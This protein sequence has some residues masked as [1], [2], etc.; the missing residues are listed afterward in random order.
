M[1]GGQGRVPM[2]MRMPI[3]I[4]SS[5]AA[6]HSQSLEAWFAHIPGLV[7]VTPSTPADNH[8]LLLAALGKLSDGLM[9]RWERRTLAWRDSVGAAA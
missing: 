8:G 7:V 6:Q 9:R 3:G 4:W 5:S 1:F 2:V